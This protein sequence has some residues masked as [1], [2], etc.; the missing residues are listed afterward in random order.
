MVA[1]RHAVAKSSN[2]IRARVSGGAELV[3]RG[4]IRWVLRTFSDASASRK[5]GI[6][7]MAGEGLDL[8]HANLYGS[9]SWRAEHGPSGSA[10]ARA[11]LRLLRTRRMNWMQRLGGGVG[12]LV[13]VLFSRAGGGASAR[14]P[15]ARWSRRPRRRSSSV[16]R[17]GCHP[18]L[19]PFQYGVDS[20]S[21][22]NRPTQHP[23]KPRQARSHKHRQS[24]ATSI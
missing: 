9:T 13:F 4:V 10:P 1:M 15:G 18:R 19:L 22:V 16:V 5:S 14:G 7:R 12:E 20:F 17:Q 21:T 8:I 11:P 24:A 23:A 2:R 3:L 6:S